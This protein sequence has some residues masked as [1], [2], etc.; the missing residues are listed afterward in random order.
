MRT[1]LRQATKMVSRKESFFIRYSAFS[2]IFL[3]GFVSALCHQNFSEKVL[4]CCH[5]IFRASFSFL[6]R[7]VGGTPGD[8]QRNFK[9]CEWMSQ[10]N[11]KTRKI[12]LIFFIWVFIRSRYS[13]ILQSKKKMI[14]TSVFSVMCPAFDVCVV[15]QKKSINNEKVGCE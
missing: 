5:T 3:F 15:L 6:L 10:T 12:L 4:Y 1:P 2:P 8:A 7:P 11:K 13:V 14:T 9:N